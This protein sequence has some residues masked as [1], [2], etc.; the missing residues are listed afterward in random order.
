MVTRRAPDARRR[1]ADAERSIAAIVQAAATAFSERPDV[2]L[3]DVARAA[4]VGRVTLYAHFPTRE[5]LL[6][7]AVEHAVAEA[8]TALDAARIDDGPADE[9]VGR[10]VRLAWPTLDRHRGL[11]TAAS[12]LHPSVLRD[13][14]SAVLERIRRLI[15]RGQAEGSIRADLSADWLVTV[16][17]S[18]MHGAAEA[19]NDRRLDRV[20]AA[21]ALEK[22]VGG[23]LATPHHPSNAGAEDR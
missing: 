20:D 11:H 9:A 7:A 22:A 18:L 12:V 21:D 23:A 3:T 4:G 13:R 17:Y 2:S 1:R 16:C 15:E 10:L 19:V 14:H 5:G 8:A 6:E